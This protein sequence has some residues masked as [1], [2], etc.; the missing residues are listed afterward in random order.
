MENFDKEFENLP[1]NTQE[2]A[3]NTLK[4]AAAKYLNTQVDTNLY[5]ELAALIKIRKDNE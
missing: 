4:K 1:E 2:V 3:L 5:I